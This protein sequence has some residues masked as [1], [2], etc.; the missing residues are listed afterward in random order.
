MT[1]CKLTNVNLNNV[2]AEDLICFFKKLSIRI[3]KPLTSLLLQVVYKYLIASTLKR[4]CSLLRI[5]QS[6]AL[7]F[8]QVNQPP[9]ETRVYLQF[10]KEKKRRKKK[11]KQE[12]SHATRHI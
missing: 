3:Y 4:S 10:Y 2:T 5:H 7:T 9:S 8:F 12:K 11:N 1:R 6:F